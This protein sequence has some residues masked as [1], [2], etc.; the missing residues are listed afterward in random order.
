MERPKTTYN[1]LQPTQKFQQ[2]PTTTSKTS[3]ATRKKHYLG[4]VQMKREPKRRLVK[5]FRSF[6]TEVIKNVIG[7]LSHFI[8]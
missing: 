2:R 7:M 4:P 8:S 6:T 3:T 1:H 5:F